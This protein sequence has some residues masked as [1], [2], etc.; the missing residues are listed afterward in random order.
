[1]TE[2]TEAECGS[3]WGKFLRKHCAM[4]AIAI[5]AGILAV[6][7][8][9]YVFTWF[10]GQAQTTGLVPSSLGSWSMNNMV[11]FIL[12]LVFW[13]LLFIG[14]PAA[15]AAGAGWMWWK[16]LPEEEKAH[17]FGGKRSKSSSAGGGVS[18]LL[19]IAFALKVYFDGNWN[20]AIATWNL[21]YIVSSMI[22]IL[23]WI[24]AIFAIPAI[25]GIIWW[26]HHEMNKKP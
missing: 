11:M 13:E 17:H 4:F 25:A 10:A 19:F 26:I 6:V 24:A 5:V 15:I 3:D 1:M 9:V 23:I 8:A 18:F 7:G 20:A 16:R 2:Q 21:D 22:T 14:I 12:H